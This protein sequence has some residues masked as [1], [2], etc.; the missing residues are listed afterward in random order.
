MDIRKIFS[1]SP[2]VTP[3]EATEILRAKS[4]AVFVDVRGDD[5]WNEEHVEGMRH[6]PLHELRDHMEE[7][8]KFP[9]VYFLCRSGGRSGSACREMREA[10]YDNAVNIAGG[11]IAWKDAG[12]PTT[13]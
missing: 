13:R 11:I 6:I 1:P 4:G 3:S 12:L 9:R 10:G 2:S 5:E 8:G 7:L